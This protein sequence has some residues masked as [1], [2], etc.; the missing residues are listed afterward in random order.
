MSTTCPHCGGPQDGSGPSDKCD[1]LE[2]EREARQEKAEK[3]AEQKA[4][5]NDSPASQNSHGF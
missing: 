1:C 4:N 3:E 5:E 2:A